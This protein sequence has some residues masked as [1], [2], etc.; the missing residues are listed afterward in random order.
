MYT[1]VK[2]KWI[3]DLNVRSEAFKLLGKKKSIGS[4]L[5]VTLVTNFVS[6]SKRKGNENKNKQSKMFLH[7]KGNHQENEKSAY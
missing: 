6:D 7:S 3:K 4:K 1:K 5:F 2:P